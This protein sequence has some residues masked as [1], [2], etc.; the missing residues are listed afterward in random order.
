MPELMT[1]NAAC[2][3]AQNGAGKHRANDAPLRNATLPHDRQQPASRS[4]ETTEATMQRRPVSQ[5]R[6]LAWPI[7]ALLACLASA[8]PARADT[9]ALSIQMTTG[10]QAV[11]SLLELQRIGFEGDTLVVAKAGA[12]ER[13]ATEDIIKIEFLMESSAV[14][15]PRDAAV[16]VKAMH[17]FQNQPNPSSP[18]TRIRFDLPKAGPVGLSIYSVNGRL[19]RKLVNDTRPAGRHITSRDGRND[20]GDKVGSGV[21]FYR[22][23]AQGAEESRRMILLP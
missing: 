6:C 23:T 13:Y 2:E 5:V 14:Q 7:L 1:G 9:P 19:I 16:L 22:L 15:D 20:A 21:Y 12:S 18:D 4:Q 8:F 11:Y 17:L 3:D 10:Q